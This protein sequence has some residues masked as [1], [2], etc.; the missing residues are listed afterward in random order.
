MLIPIPEPAK[1]MKI[2][3]PFPSDTRDPVQTREPAKIEAPPILLENQTCA[4]CETSAPVFF[5][6]CKGSPTLLC[7]GCFLPH[8]AKAP[9]FPH[10]VFPLSALQQDHDSY[11]LGFNRLG[12]NTTALRSNVT[13]M[14]KCC[15]EYSALIDSVVAQLQLQ[16][17]RKIREIQAEKGKFSREVEAAVQEAETCMSQRTTQRSRLAQQ[18]CS[19][20]TGELE[21][22][23]Y[24]VTP[25]DIQQLSESWLTY[26]TRKDYPAVK[27]SS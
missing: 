5:C 12:R 23:T 10:P 2:I 19:G 26:S 8:Q 6:S 24:Q 7:A 21:R 27:T 14:E 3:V 15:E 11:L 4:L 13:R 25:P 17:E 16:K 18:L 9:T 22:F 20:G 1:S